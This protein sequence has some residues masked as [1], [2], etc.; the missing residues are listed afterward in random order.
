MCW[1]AGIPPRRVDYFK[2]GTAGTPIE[3]VEGPIFPGAKEPTMD[4]TPKDQPSRE[5][6]I[7]I[8]TRRIELHQRRLDEYTSLRQYLIDTEMENGGPAESLIASLL[9]RDNEPRGGY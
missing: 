8:L 4:R 6:A 9:I 3:A 1:D 2:V 7:Q 5:S